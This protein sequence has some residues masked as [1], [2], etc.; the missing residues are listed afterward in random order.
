MIASKYGCVTVKTHARRTGL[1]SET[2]KM[3]ERRAK[4]WI[5]RSAPTN[6][7][8]HSGGPSGSLGTSSGAMDAR[9]GRVSFFF[10][11]FFPGAAASFFSLRR[12]AAARPPPP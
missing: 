5:F 10:G 12:A 9:L 1:V 11:F 7:W 6:G 3:V 4:W 8:H 2:Q